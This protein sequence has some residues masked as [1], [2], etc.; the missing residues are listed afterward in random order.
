MFGSEEGLGINLNSHIFHSSLSVPREMTVSSSFPQTSLF[1]F[2]IVNDTH[3]SVTFMLD[4]LTS[5]AD[6]VIFTL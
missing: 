4:L 1:P 5:Y 3:R 6:S 2:H